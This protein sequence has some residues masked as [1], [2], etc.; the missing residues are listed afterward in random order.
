[1][2]DSDPLQHNT[3]SF[4]GYLKTLY[5]SDEGQCS[6]VTIHIYCLHPAQADRHQTHG[7][8]RFCSWSGLSIPLM[9]STDPWDKHLVSPL[10]LPHSPLHSSQIKFTRIHNTTTTNNNTN[11]ATTNGNIKK[12]I[13]LIDVRLNFPCFVIAC[14][15][16]IIFPLLAIL[17]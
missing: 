9:C 2:L 14:W 6:N 16:A 5:S 12:T 8:Q 3:K 13:G 1:M 10:C 4:R 17:H 11:T 15:C 7:E